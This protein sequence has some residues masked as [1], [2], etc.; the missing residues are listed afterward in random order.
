[1]DQPVADFV[2]VTREGPVCVLTLSYPERRNAFSLPL[3]T[4]LLAH[5]QELMYR[6][7]SCRAI[8][9][10]GA[11]NTFCAGGDLSE[12]KERTII[13]ARQVFDLTRDLVRAMVNGPK[14]VIA[15]VE[16]AAFG[17]GLS[18]VCACDYVVAAR[19]ARMCGAF[20]RVGLMPDTCILWTLPRRVGA[21]K[22]RELMM[23][24]SEFDGVEAHRIGVANQTA[25]PGKALSAAKEVAR[26]MAALPPLAL[27]YLKTAMGGASHAPEA[28]V[29]AEVDYQSVLRYASAQHPDAH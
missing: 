26:V 4:K 27:A 2:P 21:G 8:V 18:L 5:V 3:R 10:T 17:M 12:M 7:S 24:A 15:A 23:L 22:A 16:G 29:R 20:V 6:D 14:P 25:E 9:L 1:M 28:I 13:E 11:G 19:N